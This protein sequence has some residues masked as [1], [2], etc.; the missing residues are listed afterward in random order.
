M[1]EEP[2]LRSLDDGTLKDGDELDALLEASSQPIYRSHD[3]VETVDDIIFV[4]H[5]DQKKPD[6]LRGLPIY[7]QDPEG[8]REL[9]GSSYRKIPIGERFALEQ[10]LVDDRDAEQTGQRRVN[11]SSSNTDIEVWSHSY[12]SS[13]RRWQHY[14]TPSSTIKSPETMP[15]EQDPLEEGIYR[16]PP[17]L[18]TNHVSPRRATGD[19]VG[20]LADVKQQLYREIAAIIEDHGAEPALLGSHLLG[21]AT[22]ESDMDIAVFSD[23]NDIDQIY[24]AIV[25]QTDADLTT[26]EQHHT[27]KTDYTKQVRYGTREVTMECDI[28]NHQ[29]QLVF[30]GIP[31]QRQ[32]TAAYGLPVA[33]DEMDLRIDLLPAQQEVFTDY[34]LPGSGETPEQVEQA[35]VTVTDDTRAHCVPAV[36]EVSSSDGDYDL[37]SFLPV[38]KNSL[39]EGDT[40]EVT[41]KLY[42]RHDTMYLADETDYVQPAS[43]RI[44]LPFRDRSPDSLEISEQDTY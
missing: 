3:Y 19:A 41:G 44:P 6:E 30:S 34:A 29:Q 42:E 8:D 5:G 2:L 43:G 22:Q 36:Y 10:N 23:T 13:D 9:D 28:T 21:T 35:Q 16:F 15:Y 12:S 27:V 18:V 17:E 38:F 31:K 1:T 33:I 32:T 4:L 14:G 39:E 24:T 37:V 25:D 40:I 11:D 26:T 20:R 7:V